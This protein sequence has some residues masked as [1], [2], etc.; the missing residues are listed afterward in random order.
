MTPPPL[1]SQPTALR[2]TRTSHAVTP[3][4]IVGKGEF[5]PRL[6]ALQI[7]LNR[8]LGR[9]PV[10]AGVDGNMAANA[11]APFQC[12]IPRISA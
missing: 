4:M 9:T 6:G 3:M 11:S 5:R 12:E 7:L 8:K 1:Q 2:Q 10:I